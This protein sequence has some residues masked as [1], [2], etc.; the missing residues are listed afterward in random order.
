MKNLYICGWVGGM[1]WR[2]ITGVV[3]CMSTGGDGCN[4][5]RHRSRYFFS[6]FYLF[7][8]WFPSMYLSQRPSSASMRRLSLRVSGGSYSILWRCCLSLY[9]GQACLV[10]R[11]RGGAGERWMMD[12]YLRKTSL[13][14]CAILT[15]GIGEDSTD[16]AWW[17]LE[18]LV[19]RCC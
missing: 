14:V 11:Q 2:R 17:I 7:L 10:W 15:G 19:Y 6:F 9:G 12:T 13:A 3:R 16:I 1:R 8:C 4:R 18:S 5:G